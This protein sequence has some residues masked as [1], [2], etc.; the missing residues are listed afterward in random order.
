VS[1]APPTTTS[2]DDDRLSAWLDGEL[3]DLEQRELEAELARDPALRADLEALEGVVRLVREEAPTV[4]PPGFHQRVMAHVAELEPAPAPG[5]VAWV[6]SWMRRWETVLLV[7][8]AAAAMLMIVPFAPFGGAEAPQAE[9]DAETSPGAVRL[10]SPTPSSLEA[11]PASRTTREPEVQEQGVDVQMPA[12]QVVGRARVEAPS[13][14]DPEAARQVENGTNLTWEDGIEPAAVPS[15]MVEPPPGDAGSEPAGRY[16][17]T[18]DDPALKR[19]VLALAARYG[20]VRDT[21]GHRVTTA[22]RSGTEELLV[23]VSQA[24]LP[25]FTRGLAGL[26]FDVGPMPSDLLAGDDVQLRLVLEGGAAGVS[27]P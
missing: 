21:S 7:G 5:L 4:A 9:P 20:E 15:G 17:V 27:A 19:R 12:T 16:V 13:P 25:A 8:V 3:S 18:S 24:E 1:Q 23:T 14:V 10:T 26:G 6:S 11:P 2:S 22:E